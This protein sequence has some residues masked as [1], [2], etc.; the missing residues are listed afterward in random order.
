[1]NAR[2]L[3]A[4]SVLVLIFAGG[5]ASGESPVVEA[6]PIWA[7]SGERLT[8]DCGVEAPSTAQST[9]GDAQ[10]RLACWEQG[11]KDATL[12]IGYT[13]KNGTK[14]ELVVPLAEFHEG[15][16]RPEE[17]LWSPDGSAFLINGS[18][19]AFA[20]S[21]FFV[22]RVQGSALVHSS[23]TRAAQTNMLDR[24][25]GCWPYIREIVG[26]APQ[27]NMS[28]ISWT[29]N[30]LAVFAEVPCSSSYENSMCSVYG[31]ELD[32]T[33]GAVARVLSAEEV[34]KNWRPLMS[35]NMADPDL[36]TCDPQTG[37]VKER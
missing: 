17:I 18:E 26:R 34:R 7:R 19:N 35:W 30:S 29:A 13:H 16:W 37:K 2:V 27:F 33:S 20:G 14:A 10:V 11:S 28:A 23:I 12:R 15:A 25:A 6:K 5:W 22:F 21:D 1:M 31:Y 3:K 8:L 36:P 24:L 32:A 9:H 4:L